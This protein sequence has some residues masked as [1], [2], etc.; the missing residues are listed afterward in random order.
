[1]E[2]RIFILSEKLLEGMLGRGLER[3]FKLL[4]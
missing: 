2:S 4:N 3:L 1:M